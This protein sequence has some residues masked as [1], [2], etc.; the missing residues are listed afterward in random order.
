MS[1]IKITLIRN[2]HE[3]DTII[4]TTLTIESKMSHPSS[5]ECFKCCYCHHVVIEYLIHQTD[6]HASLN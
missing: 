6:K 5:A 1:A 2:E 4:D 3:N